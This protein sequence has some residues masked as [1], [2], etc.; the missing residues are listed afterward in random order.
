MRAA[1]SLVRKEFS[2]YFVSPVAYVV[3]AVFLAVTGYLFSQTLLELTAEGPQ[4]I[5]FP[6][7]TMLGLGDFES[8]GGVLSFLLFWVVFLIIPPLLTMRLL[9]EE[10]ATGT[11]EMLL[12][13][14]LR[15]WQIVFSKYIACFLFYVVLWLPTLIYLAPMLNLGRA[16]EP[17]DAWPVVTT[18]LGLL[19]AGA[20]FLA[21]GLL[22]SSFVRSPMLSVFLSLFVSLGFIVA[23]VFSPDMGLGTEWYQLVF[24]FTVPMH[25]ERNF[26]R[27]LL[28]TRQLVLYGSVALFCLFV[29]VRSLESR[30]WK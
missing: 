20:M 12:T 22:V 6:M 3:L 1:L 8:R 23:G 21:I 5:E 16:G 28:D 30:R 19:L 24:F 29:T 25:F 27:G 18:Y 14:P 10:R 7:Q 2:G 15:D 4:G 17:V 26:T 11:L 13:S 9:A